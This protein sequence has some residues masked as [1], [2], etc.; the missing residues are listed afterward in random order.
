MFDGLGAGAVVRGFCFLFRE[1]FYLRPW[2]HDPGIYI[3]NLLNIVLKEE[4]IESAGPKST[5]LEPKST[6]VT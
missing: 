2:W 1:E 5:E 6:N 4:Q 3:Q